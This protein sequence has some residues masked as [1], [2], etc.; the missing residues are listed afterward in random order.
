MPFACTPPCRAQRFCSSNGPACLL[1]TRPCRA[2]AIMLVG[3]Y[4]SASPFAAAMQSSAL[5]LEQ[6]RASPSA[7][8][9]CRA[10]RF[11]APWE[12]TPVPAVRLHAAMQSS[13]VAHQPLPS[14]RGL[15]L[16]TLQWPSATFR[17]ALAAFSPH[18]VSQPHRAQPPLLPGTFCPPA[19]SRHCKCS[20][21][22]AFPPRPSRR[23]QLLAAA[24]GLLTA[25]FRLQPQPQPQPSAAAQPYAACWP[26][27]AAAR[28][29][30]YC[31][32]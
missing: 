20:K 17:S 3:T 1:F 15:L 14:R 5:A 32:C 28:C 13:S 24:A 22:A 25:A 6:P 30:A 4:C 8:T 19:P 9:P 16:P 27:S 21:A 7:C 18:P 2:Q 12:Q 29:A 10:Q 11:S 26:L 23:R 31:P